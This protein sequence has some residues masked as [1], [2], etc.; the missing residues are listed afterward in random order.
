MHINIL[1]VFEY[2]YTYITIIIRMYMYVYMHNTHIKKNVCRDNYGCI[3]HAYIYISID[4][5]LRTDDCGFIT[6]FYKAA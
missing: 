3:L 1:N 2:V 4:N 5:K 6:I